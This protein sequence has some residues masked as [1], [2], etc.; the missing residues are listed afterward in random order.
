MYKRQELEELIKKQCLFCQIVEKKVETIKIYED[1]HVLV[2]LDLYPAS[3][4]HILI[5]PRE[6]F[7]FLTEIPD[8]LVTKL[9]LVLKEVQKGLEEFGFENFNVYI[10]EGELAGQRVPHFCINLIPRKGKEK[11]VFEWEKQQISKEKL[12]E[13][14]SKLKEKLRSKAEQLKEKEKEGKKKSEQEEIEKI[15]EHTKERIP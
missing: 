8:I 3:L 4:G 11:V 9:F 7:Q 12:E 15:L 2:L 5:I 14:A 1:P 6:H 13:F 10:A